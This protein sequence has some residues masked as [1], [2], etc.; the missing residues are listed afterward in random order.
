VRDRPPEPP[1]LLAEP[2]AA[3]TYFA[4]VLGAQ[5]PTGR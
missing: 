3:A 4:P 2:G 5:V 1:A